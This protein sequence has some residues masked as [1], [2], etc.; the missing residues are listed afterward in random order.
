MF[1]R[2]A[3]RKPYVLS[4]LPMSVVVV[5]LVIISLSFTA[6][7][8]QAASSAPH[9]DVMQLNSAIDPASLRYLTNSIS[10]AESDGA[11][12]L[13]IEVD[14]PGGDIES[15]NSM[16]EAELNSTV[17]IIAYVSPSGAQAASAG[18]FVTLAAHVAIMAPTTRIGASSPVTSS[19]GDIGSTLKSKIENDL[20][21]LLTGVQNRY[22]RNVAPALLMVTKAASY[23][24][25]EAESQ[26]IV[27]CASPFDDQTLQANHVTTCNGAS[28]L[29]DLLNKIDGRTVVLHSGQSVTLHTAGIS[30]QNLDPSAVDTLYSLLIDP[31]I[32]FLL[33][34]VAVV[35]IFV[36]ISHPGA[37]V[38]G[39]TGGIALILFLFGAGSLAPN[40]AG[41]AL[42][43]LSFV[44]LV[45]DVKLTTHGV[46]TI[47]AVISLIVGALLFFNSGGPYSGSQVNPVIV[48]AMG[49]LVGLVGLYVVTLIIRMRRSPVTTGTEGMIGNTAVAITPLLPEGRVNYQGEDWSAVL[50]P[51]VMSADPGSEVRIVAVDGLRLHV[52]PVV[53]TLTNPAPKY[54]RGS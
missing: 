1:S 27:D 23:S 10:T 41:L 13:V 12:A 20:V 36:E 43:A 18:A 35:G 14:T 26:H 44:L 53:D 50:E 39:V 34:I 9:V 31:N 25:A 29:S 51:P 15:M 42:M 49:G 46:L 8:A 17:P 4:L 5:G 38:P 32:V 52:K 37:I 3:D 28:S 7:S 30:V 6:H 47:G 33:F 16:Y 54:I 11:Q 40:W 22:H 45:L 48:F 21:Q 24:D 2:R 19:G